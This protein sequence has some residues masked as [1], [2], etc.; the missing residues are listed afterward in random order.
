[1]C[2]GCHS[3]NLNIT[4]VVGKR[5]GHNRLY[6]LA[7]L[8]VSVVE[9]A[10]GTH[11]CV[12]SDEKYTLSGVPEGGARRS[13]PCSVIA[14]MLEYQVM[15]LKSGYIHNTTKNNKGH[16]VSVTVMGVWGSQIYTERPTAGAR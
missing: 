14:C 10:P 6:S 5:L 4:P 12:D 13:I 8:R 2:T 15:V 16:M 3:E 11:S 1:M 9:K 7:S